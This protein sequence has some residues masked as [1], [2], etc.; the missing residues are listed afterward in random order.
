MGKPK[1]R[2]VRKYVKHPRYGDKPISFDY[3]ATNDEIMQGY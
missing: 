2:S 3:A 1:P